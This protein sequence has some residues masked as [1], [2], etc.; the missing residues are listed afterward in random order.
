MRLN[1]GRGDGRAA[2]RGQ[3]AGDG[4]IDNLPGMGYLIVMSPDSIGS[5]I[6][7]VIT[8][9]TRKQNT[10]LVTLR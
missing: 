2:K 8:G 4:G 1:S 7:V 6:E 5:G 9:L 10:I 3:V